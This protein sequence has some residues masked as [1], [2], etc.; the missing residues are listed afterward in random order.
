LRTQAG[1]QN[2]RG[3]P[4]S[5]ALSNNEPARRQIKDAEG[6]AAASP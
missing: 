4:E 6:D 2:E 3:A 1:P 5:G